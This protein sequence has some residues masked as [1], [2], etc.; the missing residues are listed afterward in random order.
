[1]YDQVFNI[2]VLLF[3]KDGLTRRGTGHP[4]PCLPAPTLPGAHHIQFHH[5][6]KTQSHRA[7]AV[8]CSV[9]G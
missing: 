6:K 5:F 8:P 4:D 7:Q 1:M 3:T 9:P 2:L